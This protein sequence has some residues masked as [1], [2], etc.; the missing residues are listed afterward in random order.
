MAFRRA[1]ATLPVTILVLFLFGCATAP[2]APDA[3]DWVVN[4]RESSEDFVYFVASGSSE[5]GNIVDAEERA[6]LAGVDEIVRYLGARVEIE[7]T[8]E[9]RASLDTFEQRVDQQLRQQSEAR[10]A[11][12]RVIDKYVDES[13]S[14]TIVYMLVRYDRSALEAERDRL[15]ALLEERDDAVTVPERE[16]GRAVAEGQ[17]VTAIARHI[18]AAIAASDER[19][20]NGEIKMRRNLADAVTIARGLRIQAERERVEVFVSDDEVPAFA[21]RVSA[22][23]E[24][25][26]VPDARVVFS[27]PERSEG[28]R[29]IV[30]SR[31]ASADAEG[32]AVFTPPPPTSVGT[33]TV[34]A[35]LATRE[36]LEP[37][38]AIQDQAAQEIAALRGTLQEVRASIQY[39]VLSEAR[40]VPTGV[41]A[42]DTDI[43]GNP[44]GTNST[45]TGI[46]QELSA[47]GFTVQPLPFDASRLRE[48]EASLLLRE[49]RNRFGDE[50]S[51]V[52]LGVGQIEEFNEENG[53]LVTVSGSVQAY[54]LSTGR[55]LHASDAFQRSR[56]SSSTGAIAAAFRSLGG[57]LAD[58]VA[59][60]LP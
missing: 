18:E 54:E 15:Q 20:D 30:R 14:R 50:V 13:G 31:T 23:P 48:E 44:V 10:L 37:L 57:K 46:M 6:I 45:A 16:A 21:A 26:P 55:S 2:Q 40:D 58:E 49:I 39:V 28:G 56:G 33:A 32:L 9:V 60:N 3:P 29:T 41:I 22:G 19:V 4:G 53:F 59:A 34:S 47:A 8:A 43:A 27:Y 11:G 25:T 17:L 7:S 5:T 36:L 52:I 35:S 51:R 38:D 1:N 24:Q 12:L 42:L